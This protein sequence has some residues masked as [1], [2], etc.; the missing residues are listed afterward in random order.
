[1]T[2]TTILMTET[3]VKIEMIETLQYF[4]LLYAFLFITMI[5]LFA[6]II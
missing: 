4:S 3:S 5:Q 2:H 1:M 6:V